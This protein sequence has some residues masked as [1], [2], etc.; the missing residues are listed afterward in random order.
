MVKVMIRPMIAVLG[1]PPLVVLGG[2]V[3]STAFIRSSHYGSYFFFCIVYGFCCYFIFRLSRC[4]KSS[5]MLW[6]P[7]LVIAWT[8]PFVLGHYYGYSNTKY[9]VWR[10]VQN[11]IAGEFDSGWKNLDRNRVFDLYVKS[12][13][14][15]SWGG[16]PAYLSLMAHEGWSGYERSAGIGA[17][18]IE[19]EGIWVWI[20]WVMHLV[21]LLVATAVAMGATITEADVKKDEARLRKR[22]ERLPAAVQ[23]PPKPR[24]Q[25]KKTSPEDPI[26][27][28]GAVRTDVKPE[29]EQ[30]QNGWWVINVFFRER[31]A[32]FRAYSP[33]TKPTGRAFF[34]DIHHAL[35]RLERE[36]P[37]EALAVLGTVEGGLTANEAIDKLME[38]KKKIQYVLGLDYSLFENDER[39]FPIFFSGDGDDPKRA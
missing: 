13:T 12:V 38:D 24:L 11:D 5:A 31:R 35:Y 33:D 26:R 3:Y 19:R 1:I 30:E 4:I 7:V 9:I 25:E 39:F 15:H 14:G 21:F 16:F 27:T 18:Y 29:D 10:M 37:L 2:L 8:G 34:E 22:Y 20:A 36:G 6:V 28:G 23:P 32:T 17:I